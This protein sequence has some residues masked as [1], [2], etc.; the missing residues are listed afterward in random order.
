MRRVI[1]PMDWR[2]Y[3]ASYIGH[4]IQGTLAGAMMLHWPLVGLALLIL[5]ASYQGLEFARR[6]DT[7]G[8][9]MLHFACGFYI[10]LAGV[11]AVRLL[12]PL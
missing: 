7:P 6:N 1:P 5:Y 8:R 9:D 3:W 2:R 12:S 10:G 4:G 11:F